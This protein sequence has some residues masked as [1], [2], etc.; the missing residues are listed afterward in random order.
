MV[1][2]A[3]VRSVASRVTRSFEVSMV[4]VAPVRTAPPAVYPE[5]VISESN[6]SEPVTH[7]V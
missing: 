4:A 7:R 5:P 3:Q 6:G 2:V 1:E